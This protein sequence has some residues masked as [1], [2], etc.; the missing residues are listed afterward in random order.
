MVYWYQNMASD[1]DEKSASEPTR[2][3]AVIDATH[4][5]KKK[6]QETISINI[7]TAVIALSQ[8][9]K[10]SEILKLTATIRANEK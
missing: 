7:Q 1:E 10:L 8:S 6:V 2:L 3:L 5:W 9:G 4:G